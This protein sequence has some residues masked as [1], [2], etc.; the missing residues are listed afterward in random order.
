MTKLEIGL[1]GFS[2][3]PDTPGKK[4]PQLRNFP[5]LIGLWTICKAFSFFKLI[6]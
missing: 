1:D 4:E 6:F 5:Y 3:Q 2:Y